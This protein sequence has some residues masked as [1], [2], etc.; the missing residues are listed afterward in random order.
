MDGLALAAAPRL[1]VADP[2]PGASARAGAEDADDEEAADP[3][4]DPG[5]EAEAEAE[6]EAEPAPRDEAVV[7]AEEGPEGAPGAVGI[8]VGAP[9]WKFGTAAGDMSGRG[10]GGRDE[11]KEEETDAPSGDH[12]LEGARLML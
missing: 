4:P 9:K 5:T 1:L 6:D 8:V 2:A 12:S 7:A 10:V 3:E 11:E